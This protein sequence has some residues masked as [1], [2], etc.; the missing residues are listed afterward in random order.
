MHMNC[1]HWQDDY[2]TRSLANFLGFSLPFASA[3]PHL[4]LCPPLCAK[5]P[6]HMCKSTDE[7]FPIFPL[8]FMVPATALV[9]TH[10]LSF[11]TQ[12]NLL[13][14]LSVCLFLLYQ[15]Q[16]TLQDTY[17]QILYFN[18][19]ALIS[20]YPHLSRIISQVLRCLGEIWV[21]DGK[22]S[23]SLHF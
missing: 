9:L 15:F 17:P 20:N 13:T 21:S 8:C 5:F 16:L 14:F 4:Y 22:F 19:S 7:I 18:I 10:H 12:S 6:V 11:G 2:Y 3:I 1:M 23:I